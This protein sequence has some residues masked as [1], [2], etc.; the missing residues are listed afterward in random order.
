M[1]DFNFRL[2][3]KCLKVNSG[4]INYMII[5]RVVSYLLH[6]LFFCVL[7]S[8]P[9]WVSCFFNSIAQNDKF[10]RKNNKSDRVVPFTS[11]YYSS[12]FPCWWVIFKK[13]C[14]LYCT[15][16]WVSLGWDNNSRSSLE[17][18]ILLGIVLL[19]NL[20]SLFCMYQKEL[21]LKMLIYSWISGCLLYVVS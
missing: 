8:F 20:V 10:I 17:L 7:H 6:V 9:C 11:S 4:L 14:F 1:L 16:S 15:L 12:S 5:H 2:Y 3:V 19:L 18:L 13:P 21:K